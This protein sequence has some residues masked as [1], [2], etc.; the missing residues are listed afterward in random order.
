MAQHL[1]GMAAQY[2]DGRETGVDYAFAKDFVAELPEVVDGDLL[3]ARK[4]G[5]AVARLPEL[6]TNEGGY[7]SHDAVEAAL[8]GIRRGRAL[9]RGE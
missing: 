9:E 2:D 7:D 3:E 1:R 6:D 5:I 8:A 4:I